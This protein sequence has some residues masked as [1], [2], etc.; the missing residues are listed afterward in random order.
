[1]R[2][3]ARGEEWRRR[4][5][6]PL[7]LAVGLLAVAG[8]AAG[9]TGTGA[10]K[11]G[12]AVEGAWARP[13][14][15]G[16]TSAVYFTVRNTGGVDDRLTGASTDVAGETPLH[17]TVAEG[18]DAGAGMQMQMPQ[19]GMM[20]MR[21]VE[22]VS[23]PAGGTVEFKPGGLHVMLMDLK[24]DLKP[25]DTFSLTLKFEKAGARSVE[26]TVRQP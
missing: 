13:G 25:G 24:R 6:R 17:E 4:W 18:G 2:V 3:L 14:E 10:P 5:V 16:G 21:P 8:M 1:M 22:A 11:G 20:R 19:G 23:V 15:K 9:C 12:V 7:A 26:V